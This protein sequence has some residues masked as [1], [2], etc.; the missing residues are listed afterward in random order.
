MGM[1][2]E[3]WVDKRVISALNLK[4]PKCDSFTEGNQWQTKSFDNLMNSYY[5]TFRADDKR[6]VLRELNDPHD[7]RFWHEYT[8]EEIDEMRAKE[9]GHNHQF[10]K[11]F[12]DMWIAE[13]GYWKEDAYFPENRNSESMHS[14]PHQWVEIHEICSSCECFISIKLKFTDGVVMDVIKEVK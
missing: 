6:I 11:T 3:V 9:K 1:F 10:M 4:C 13:S 8:Q 12:H 14:L 7:K 2:D 5:L